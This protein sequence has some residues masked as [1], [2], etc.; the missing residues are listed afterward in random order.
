M[1]WNFWE[2]VEWVREQPEHVRRRYVLGCLAVSMIFIF[3]IWILSIKE[4][5]QNMSKETPA[6]NLKDKLPNNQ[7][8]S[9]NDL[10]EKAT[11]LRVDGQSEKTGAEYFDEQIQK[12]TQSV[13]ENVQE[14]P[15]AP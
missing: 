9:L 15:Q 14:T 8:S 4:S 12:N 11:P 13:N 10:L 5:F 7:T 6:M 3:G 2:K 1:T